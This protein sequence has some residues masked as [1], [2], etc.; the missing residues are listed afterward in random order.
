MNKINA[1]IKQGLVI[2]VIIAATAVLSSCEKYKFSPPEVDPN[3][4]WSLSTDIQP[5]FNAKCISCHGGSQQPDLREGRSFESLT[6]RGYVTKPAE[7]SKLFTTL[8]SGSHESRTT[9]VEKLKIRYW[10]EQ[11]AKN[12]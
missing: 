3:A 4:P 12:N 1:G 5:I 8:S 9:A 2:F 11:G 7:S 6:K 10:I